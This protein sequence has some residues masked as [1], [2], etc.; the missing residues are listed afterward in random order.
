L[1]FFTEEQLDAKWD[2]L[3]KVDNHVNVLADRGER[4]T[5]KEEHHRLWRGR[6]VTLSELRRELAFAPEEQLHAIWDSLQVD[7]HDHD[8][9]VDASLSPQKRWS[10]EAVPREVTTSLSPQKRWSTGALPHEV[11]TCIGTTFS[12]KKMR[13]V[14]AS[15]GALG[16][17]TPR[18]PWTTAQAD[19]T[20]KTARM[21]KAVKT[22]MAPMSS[23]YSKPSRFLSRGWRQQKACSK[24]RTH[25]IVFDL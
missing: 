7:N 3:K 4:L 21:A 13:L 1:A 16:D 12:P 19:A 5:S 22:G 17:L 9:P 14:P 6:S 2:G 18:V 15:R 11:T 10:E 24:I 25:R 20:A 8:D 23:S